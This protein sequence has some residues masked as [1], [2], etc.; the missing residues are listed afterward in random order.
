MTGAA[1]APDP[2]EVVATS[3]TRH[4]EWSKLAD[5]LKTQITWSRI[6]S[7][8][9]ACTGALLQTAAA[10]MGKS[11][12]GVALAGMIALVGVPLIAKFFLTPDAVRK[13]LRAR[14]ASE[15]LKSLVYRFEARAAPFHGDDRMARFTE[16]R[17]KANSWEE[18][19]AD[20]LAAIRIKPSARPGPLDPDGYITRR[21]RNQIDTYY[22]P[23]AGTNARLARLFRWLELIMAVAAA[24]L[25][26]VATWQGHSSDGSSRLG[27]WVAVVTTIGGAIAAHAAA[28]RYQLQARVYFATARRLQDLL[29]DLPGRDAPVDAE[30]WSAFVTACEEAISAENRGWMAK[31]DPDEQR[32]P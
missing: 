10:G 22:R 23:R 25:G 18:E 6:A 5:R 13:W 2:E 28:S 7:L 20:E 12:T 8:G 15:G 16:E 21:V 31:L 29:D 14:S 9:L 32:K 26:V 30:R 1:A 27:A 4:K 3:W 19:L 11:G 17:D 24:V